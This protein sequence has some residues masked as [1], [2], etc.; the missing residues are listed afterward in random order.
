[1]LH[2]RSIYVGLANDTSFTTSPA[3]N[4]MNV[5]LYSCLYLDDVSKHFTEIFPVTKRLRCK[6]K[7]TLGRRN[8][9]FVFVRVGLH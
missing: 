7:L 1:M 6:A 5:A 3:A 4:G 9:P 8:M 2:A